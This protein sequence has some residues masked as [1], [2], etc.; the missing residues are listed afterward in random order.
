M[1]IPFFI[2]VSMLVLSSPVYGI[3]ILALDTQHRPHQRSILAL[4]GGLLLKSFGLLGFVS[5][6][7]FLGGSWLA[8]LPFLVIMVASLN[9]YL[10]MNQI[11]LH[12]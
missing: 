8:W 9:I 5:L 6:S 7:W 11:T 1:P 3:I 12:Q 4:G 10:L 2:I